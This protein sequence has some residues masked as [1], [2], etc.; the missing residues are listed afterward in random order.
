MAPRTPRYRLDPSVQP[1]QVHVHVEVD[2]QRS[3][4]FRGE[5]A[6]EIELDKSRRSIRLHAVDLRLSKP[7]IEIA[8]RVRRGRVTPLPATGMIAVEFD[9]PVPAG[10]AVLHLGFAGRLR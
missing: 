8:G 2:P 5:V 6:L 9:K 1:R 7:R 4:A 10:A 3:S